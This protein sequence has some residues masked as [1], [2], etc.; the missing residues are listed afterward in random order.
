MLYDPQVSQYPQPKNAAEWLALSSGIGFSLSNVITRKSS[1]LS[2]RAKSFA[3]WIGVLVV[4][5]M[6]ILIVKAP[7]PS[8]MSF[9]LAN[10]LVLGFIS[11]LLIGAT[12]FVQYGLTKIK[13]TRASVLFLFELVVAS[14]AAYYL[15][16]ET[17]QSNEFIGGAL[18]VVAGIFAASN[19][20]E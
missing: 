9:S 20:E 7:F 13:A 17:M 18:I 1:H 5:L 4:S 2:L 10:W 3:V 8:P 12:L 14:V 16:H 15:A 6:F 11:L 19:H